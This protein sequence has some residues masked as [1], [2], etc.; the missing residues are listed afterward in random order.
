MVRVYLPLLK[1]I[2]LALFLVACSS[3]KKKVL[4][5]YLGSFQDKKAGELKYSP[6]PSPYKR[7]KHPVLDALWW[8]PKSKS[9]ISYFSSCSKAHR[10]LEEFQRGSFPQDG[11]YKLLR[12]FKSKRGL[13]SILEMYDTNKKTTYSGIYTIKKGK[14]YFN[15]NFVAGS[16]ASFDVEE[17]VFK[18][19][20]KNFHLQ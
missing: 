10:T 8:N 5:S 11:K 3:V 18:T 19:F 2:G 14:C 17:P 12:N 4:K 16:Q 20:I 7:Q 15:I 9:F 13:Y 6:P 1:F